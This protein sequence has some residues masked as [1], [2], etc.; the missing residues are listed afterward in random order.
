MEGTAMTRMISLTVAASALACIV[1]AGSA[2]AA[3]AS[4]VALGKLTNAAPA[5]ATVQQ[6]HYYR[7]RYW[8][9]HHRRHWHRWW[10]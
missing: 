5:S 1:A 8:R 6:A 3:P 10:W 7:Y 9:W 4:G 2:Q